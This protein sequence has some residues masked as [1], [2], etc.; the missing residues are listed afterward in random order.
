MIKRK[1]ESQ[2]KGFGTWHEW[3]RVSC[4]MQWKKQSVQYNVMLLH[5][6][7]LVAYSYNFFEL[8]HNTRQLF[9]PCGKR[10]GAETRW[11][12]ERVSTGWRQ[13]ASHRALAG[14][15]C[16]D[17]E[18]HGLWMSDGADTSQMIGDLVTGA[19]EAECR[20][21]VDHR[22]TTNRCARITKACGRGESAERARGR[23]CAPTRG[24]S[25]QGWASEELRA[26][27]TGRLCALG[28]AVMCAAVRLQM[29]AVKWYKLPRSLKGSYVGWLSCVWTAVGTS[30][31]RTV[32]NA[33]DAT[34]WRWDNS[35]V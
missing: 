17:A 25:Y 16:A 4:I 33:W 24:T 13:G 34:T 23:A 12:T 22:G 20:L 1:G 21:R 9:L 3:N 6:I 27:A 15:G 32:E 18:Q 29:R 26:R 19:A 10:S 14:F 28:C 31:Y 2:Q 8:L 11:A 7:I 30:S 35:T 5:D